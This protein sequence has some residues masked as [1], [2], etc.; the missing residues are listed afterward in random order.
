MEISASINARESA[1]NEA[2]IRHN[3]QNA[4]IQ[5]FSQEGK[6]LEEWNKI[7]DKASRELI[8][9]VQIKNLEDAIAG[10]SEHLDAETKLKM[11]L[12]SLVDGASQYVK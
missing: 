1:Y 10:L 4:N 8:N 7:I 5:P 9:K 12:A 6:S 3:L 2:I 11:K